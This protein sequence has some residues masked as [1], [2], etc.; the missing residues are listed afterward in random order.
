[1]IQFRRILLRLITTP[2]A[3]AK[4]APWHLMDPA[5]TP[6]QEEG[7]SSAPRAAILAS[8]R[9]LVGCDRRL[10]MK[11]GTLDRKILWE[12]PSGKLVQIQ[13][14]RLVSFSQRHVAAISHEVTLL[15]QATPIVISSEMIVPQPH[16]QNEETEPRRARM[17]A[18]ELQFERAP[19]AID[20][21]FWSTALN[22]AA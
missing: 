15:N 8:E 12:T 19:R 22:T 18:F 10:N 11:S 16:H 21:S 14:R 3:R 2:S 6:P 4:E 7:K 17:A 1:V 20:A 5:A 13:S 9:S